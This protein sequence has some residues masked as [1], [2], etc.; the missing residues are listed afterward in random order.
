MEMGEFRSKGLVDIQKALTQTG[1][2]LDARGPKCFALALCPNDMRNMRLQ[3]A[4]IRQC[5]HMMAGRVPSALYRAVSN[6]TQGTAGWQASPCF[7]T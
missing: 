7:S 1:L 2:C 4:E 5:K 6:C 3:V